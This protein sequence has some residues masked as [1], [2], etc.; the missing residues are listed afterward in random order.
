MLDRKL[1]F[2]YG[3]EK[4]NF[5]YNHN[6]SN[7]KNLFPKSHER[8]TYFKSLFKHGRILGPYMLG[9]K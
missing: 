4:S 2:K 8:M 5:S 3:L 9:I 1:E 7:F 6:T